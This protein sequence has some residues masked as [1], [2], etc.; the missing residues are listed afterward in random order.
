MRGYDAALPMRRTRHELRELGR[1]A[2]PIVLAQL[3]MMGFGIV[4][5]WMVGRLGSQALAA[6]ALA[7]VVLFGSLIFGVGL[8]MGIDPIVAQAHGAR[9]G[10][11]AGRALQQG[12]VLALPATVPI[13]LVWFFTGDLLRAMGQEESLCVLAGDY[14]R[15][16]VF[17]VAPFLVYVAMR[18]YLQGRR[19]VWPPVWVILAANVCNAFLNEAWI[20]GRFGFPEL[21]VPGAGFASG[22]TRTLMMFLLG[23][24]IVRGRLHRGAWAGWTRDAWGLVGL[25]RVLHFGLP[26]SIYICLEVWAFNGATVLAGWLGED[27]TA[28]HV[29]ALRCASLAFMVPLGIGIASATRV[30]N[31]LGARRPRRAQRAAWT[32]LAV[33]G[34]VMAVSGTIFVTLPETLARQ[35]TADPA[36]VALAVAVFPI[37]AAFQLCDGLQAVGAGILRGMGTT[38]PVAV[39]MLIAFYGVALPLGY[40]LAFHRGWGLPGLWWGLASG[41]FVVAAGLLGWVAWRGPARATAIALERPPARTAKC[42]TGAAP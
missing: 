32:A 21:G 1:L 27:A 25:R 3:G 22:V 9:D 34:A 10:A 4:D 26:I 35:F 12:M 29:I 37:A 31:L 14:A 39:L 16:Q 42:G 6:V 38:R 2:L 40:T 41:L 15:T 8:V 18:Q 5:M 20:F 7:D 28:A 36:V 11:A 13:A 30:G 24:L 19:L 33:G 23:A 17:S